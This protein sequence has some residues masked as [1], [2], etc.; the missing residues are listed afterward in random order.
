MIR[1]KIKGQDPFNQTAVTPAAH[2]NFD[3]GHFSIGPG[4]VTSIAFEE[5][6]IPPKYIWIRAR[7]HFTPCVDVPILRALDGFVWK[8]TERCQSV[9]LEPFQLLHAQKDYMVDECWTL[10]K[11]QPLF[12]HQFAI[13]P[14]LY[15]SNDGIHLW[16]CGGRMGNFSSIEQLFAQVPSDGEQV[17]VNTFSTWKQHLGDV[18]GLVFEPPTL[19]PNAII[20]PLNIM[21]K[22]TACIEQNGLEYAFTGRRWESTDAIE[23][24]DILCERNDL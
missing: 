5:I 1:S 15:A 16:P 22:F 18:D 20:S 13:A 6:P 3:I 19:P 7:L 8:G 23:F 14:T 21:G 11:Q 24:I 17:Y 12:E 4:E 2:T 9:K 10:S